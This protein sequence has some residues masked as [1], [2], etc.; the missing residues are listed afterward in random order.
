MKLFLNKI[1]QKTIK[2]RII[3]FIFSDTLL[4]SLSIWLAFLL[5][6]EGNI[7]LKT[8]PLMKN[9]IILTTLSTLPVFYYFRLYHFSWNSIGIF[10]LLRLIQAII[11]DFILIGTI[12]FFLREKFFAGFPRSVFLLS[13]FLIFF[14]CG[15]I[16]FFKRALKEF[17]KKPSSGKRILIIG[18]GD[19]GEQ[20]SRNILNEARYSHNLVGF[21]DDN[22]NKQGIF[23]H[24]IKVLGTT[25]DI[26][27][28]VERL[29]IQGVIIAIPSATGD[30]ISR[31][32][33]LCHRQMYLF[34]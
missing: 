1:F 19:A 6:F 21:I 25:K 34:P 32:Y 2:K 12:L 33:K 29:N 27:K 22:L 4:I 26:P 14:T 3:L 10:T 28:I 13:I 11:G 24:N 16:R 9:F 23:I 8:F 15:G 20:L 5:R 17:L 7:P 30:E 18:S 31:I